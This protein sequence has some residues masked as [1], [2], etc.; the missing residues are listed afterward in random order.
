MSRRQIIPVAIVAL[1]LA[2]AGCGGGEQTDPSAIDGDP[3]TTLPKE[4]ASAGGVAPARSGPL[5]KE[6][7]VTGVSTDLSK[8]PAVPEAKGRRRRICGL[9]TS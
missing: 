4:L 7:S 5:P 8:K 9:S 1:A 3:T 6:T 2:A